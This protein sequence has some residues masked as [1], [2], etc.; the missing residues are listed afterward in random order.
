MRRSYFRVQPPLV[1]YRLREDRSEGAVGRPNWLRSVNLISRDSRPLGS[2]CRLRIWVR[3]AA[4][5]PLCFQAFKSEI[6]FVW[7]FCISPSRRRLLT[8][9]ACYKRDC[10]LESHC[11]A[12]T[13]AFEVRAL[14]GRRHNGTYRRHRINRTGR[15]GPE[16]DPQHERPRLHGCGLQPHGVQGRRIPQRCGQGAQNHHRGALDRGNGFAVEAAAQSHADGEGRSGGGRFHRDGAAPPRT[17]RLHHRR[18][19]LAFPRYHPPHQI[20]GKQGPAL[21]RHGRFGR[22][23]RR[24]FRPLHDAGRQPQSL[25]AG[26][27]HLPGHLRQDA[28]GR[29]LLRLDGRRRR[30]PLRQNGPQR[31]RVRRHAAHLRGL[32]ASEG[33]ARHVERGDAPGLSRL[34]QGRAGQLPDRNHPRHPGL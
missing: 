19:Q 4:Q 29:A 3:F 24:A 7:C 6:G 2:T 5:N 1:L 32:P 30:R 23:G 21:R 17:G 8:R 26:E 28:I 15:N 13:L 20:P 11:R 12:R 18:R 27:G 9:A 31:H 34:E 16:P 33:R 14:N 10:H 25:A 22:R